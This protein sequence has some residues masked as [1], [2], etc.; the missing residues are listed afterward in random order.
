MNKKKLIGDMEWLID[1]YKKD[2]EKSKD[3]DDNWVKHCKG[4]INVLEMVLKSINEG[5]YD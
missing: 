1:N 3:I 2:I 5:I 4:S